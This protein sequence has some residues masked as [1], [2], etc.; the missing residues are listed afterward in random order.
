VMGNHR[1]TA[2]LTGQLPRASW[3]TV[4]TTRAPDPGVGHGQGRNGSTFALRLHGP[5]PQKKSDSQPLRRPVTF[6]KVPVA[7]CREEAKPRPPRLR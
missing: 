7:A 2:H 6:P 3:S 5:L 4:P 1:R